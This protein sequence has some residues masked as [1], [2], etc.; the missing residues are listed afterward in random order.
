[1]AEK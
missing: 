1:V